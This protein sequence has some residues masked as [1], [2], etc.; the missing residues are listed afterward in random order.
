MNEAAWLCHEEMS[1]VFKF[2]D[3]LSKIVRNNNL[4]Y[5]DFIADYIQNKNT[6]ISGVVTLTPTEIQFKE[7]ITMRLILNIKYSD[8]IPYAISLYLKEDLIWEGQALEKPEPA[9]CLK[10]QR[11]GD[12]F[13]NQPDYFCIFNE[14][15]D[16][17]KQYLLNLVQA[18]YLAD[19]YTNKINIRLQFIALNDALQI[20]GKTKTNLEVESDILLPIKNQVRNDYFI[21]R[22]KLINLMRLGKIT[23]SKLEEQLEKSKEKIINSVCSG[24]Q[25]CKVA[26][27][28]CKDK[29]LLPL[30]GN[31][32]RFSMDMQNP[33]NNLMPKTNLKIELQAGKSIGKKLLEQVIQ[34]TRGINRNFVTDPIPESAPGE[35]PN[36]TALKRAINTWSSLR[37]ITKIFNKVEELGQNCRMNVRNNTYNLKRKV[38]ML[39]FLGKH[40]TFFEFLGHIRNSQLNKKN[41]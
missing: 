4:K 12:T 5:Y 30:S 3:E 21:V 35:I 7:L 10:I 34:L 14:K 23:K 25:V 9:R 2:Q 8:I 19:M 22:H 29:G 28:Y 6:R 18:R 11:K 40:D 16:I 39:S 41:R 15:N 17:S 36:A 24:I 27:I 31:R 20:L 26:I 37:D 13:A 38:A 32:E 33:F 1:I